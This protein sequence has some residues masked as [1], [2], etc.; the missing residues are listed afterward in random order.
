MPLGPNLL[1]SLSIFTGTLGN[2]NTPSGWAQTGLD[3]LCNTLIN[4]PSGVVNG[5]PTFAN[6]IRETAT[7]GFQG[8]QPGTLPF[9]YGAGVNYIIG[10]WISVPTG[11]TPGSC[12][13]YHAGANGNGVFADASVLLAAPPDTYIYYSNQYNAL[14]DETVFGIINPG[15]S[16]GT[17]FDVALPS[18]QQINYVLMGQTWL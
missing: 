6:S 15:G 2:G 17:G 16:T 9:S 11:V 18:I 8:F 13:M 12:H 10:L 3:S 1:G 14:G 4:P 5:Q 7:G